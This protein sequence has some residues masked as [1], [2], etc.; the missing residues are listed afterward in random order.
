MLM[1][2]FGVINQEYYGMLWYF[3]SGQY[4]VMSLP[5]SNTVCELQ[6]RFPLIL[7]N[8]LFGFSYYNLLIPPPASADLFRKENKGRLAYFH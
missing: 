4:T 7:T 2:N 6:S 5:K 8:Y 3:W 1:Q